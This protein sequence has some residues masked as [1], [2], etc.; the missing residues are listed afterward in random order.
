MLQLQ[1]NNRVALSFC[2]RPSNAK[3]KLVLSEHLAF[4]FGSAALLVTLLTLLRVA[5]LLFNRELIGSTAWT[6]FG[7]QWNSKRT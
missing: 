1:I 4:L 2:N 7:E 3:E 6:G 5:L